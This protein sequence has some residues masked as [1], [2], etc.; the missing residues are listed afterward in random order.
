MKLADEQKDSLTEAI[1]IAFSRTA[2]ALS[3]LTSQRVVLE[4]PIID[5]HP[6]DELPVALTHLVK[7]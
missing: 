1:N 2:A 5:I 4:T 7:Q 6:I 3:D